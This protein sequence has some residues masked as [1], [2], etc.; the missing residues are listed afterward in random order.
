MKSELLFPFDAEYLMSN[1]RRIKKDLLNEG[2]SFISKK[3]AILGGST[4][5]AL[6]DMLDLFLLNQGI[7]ADFY[8]SEYNRYYEDA[9]FS[10]E[11]LDLF[12]PDIV[13]IFTT[14]KNLEEIPPVFS[15]ADSEKLW[16]DSTHNKYQTI[17]DKL[18]ERF[19]CIIIQNNVE[20]P[21]YRL[22][23]NYDM[24]HYAGVTNMIS[25]LNVWISEQI[26]QRDYLYLCDLQFISADFG[27]SK[28]YDTI[29]W[30]MYKY[31]F[32]ME[33]FPVVAFNVANIIKAIYGKNKKGLVLDL[34]NTLWG[35]VIG[36]DGQEG[37]VLGNEIPLGQAYMDFQKYLKRQKEIGILLNINS[38]NDPENATLGLLHPQSVLKKEDF[39]VVKANWESKDCNH[40][41][42]ATEINISP[43]SLVFVDDNPAER[44]IVSEQVKGVCAPDI[45]KITDYVHVLDRN[46]FFESVSLSIDDAKR[47]EMYQ[48]N[49]RRTKLQSTFRD[50]GEYLKALDMHATIKPFEKVYMSRI[51]QL[52]NKSNQF[53]LTTRRYTLSEIEDM[54]KHT[55]EYIT[56]YGSLRDKFGDNGVVSVIIGH[57]EGGICEIILWLMSCRVLKRDMECAMMDRM[58][59]IC[60]EQKVREIVGVYIPTNK[61]MMVESFY[62]ERGFSF[63]SDNNGSTTW[64]LSIDDSYISQ[65]HYIEIGD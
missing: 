56:L 23:G 17:W 11:E 43:E 7:K 47:N 51:A 14:S 3:V 35:G 40:I 52:T 61:N 33:A 13:Y 58:V 15:D 1:K 50:Y 21:E 44:L 55:D 39:V 22:L 2:K 5:A 49:V 24:V 57:V 45:G 46:G 37:I 62:R 8:V 6:K 19:S 18:Y 9:V 48:E 20:L 41:E 4:T 16:V 42:I 12:Q 54:A 27:L 60:K 38:K 34:D 28:W 31:A 32:C 53:N 25:C 10:N 29:S 64:K 26:R 30:Y 59:E 65:N 36:D 63:V